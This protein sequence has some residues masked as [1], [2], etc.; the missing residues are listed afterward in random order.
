M[1]EDI[2]RETDLRG[3]LAYRDKYDTHKGGSHIKLCCLIEYRCCALLP[4]YG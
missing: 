2:V 1:D 4:I 3:S